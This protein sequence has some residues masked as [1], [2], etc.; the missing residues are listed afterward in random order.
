MTPSRYRGFTLGDEVGIRD[1]L[2]EDW[3]AGHR[4]FVG[5]AGPG[6]VGHHRIS[7]PDG[8]G[9]EYRDWQEESDYTGNQ[10]SRAYAHIP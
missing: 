10:Y 5:S 8:I 7:A 9:V 3:G 4:R 1:G 2:I 6:L